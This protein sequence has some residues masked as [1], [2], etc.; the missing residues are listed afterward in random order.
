MNKLELIIYNFVK[1]NPKLKQK[2][3]DL[4][5][6]LLG[7]IPQKSIKSDF[8]FIERKGYFYGFHDKSPFSPNGKNLLAHKIL[9]NYQKLKKESEIEI[10]YFSGENWLNYTPIDITTG[11][12]WQLG[13]MLQWRGKSNEEIVYNIEISGKHKSRIKNIK[14][15]EI[16]KELPWAISHISPDGEYGC[17]Y[18]FHRAEKAMPGY[19]LISENPEINIDEEDF[20]RIFNI[21]TEDVTYEVSIDEIKK[22]NPQSSMENAFHFFHHT[23][24][25]PQSKRVFFLHRWLD[26]NNRRWTRM[27][28]VDVNGENL[29]L[30]PM[31]EMVSHITWASENEIFAYLRYPNDGEGYYLVEDFTGKQ[32]RFFYDK[33]N[34]DGHPTLLKEKNIVITDSYPDR[35]R[36]QYLILMDVK[37]NTRTDLMRTHLPKLFR[38][39]LQVDLHPRFHTSENIVCVD[40]AHTGQHSLITLN[41]T[42]AIT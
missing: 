34:S 35:Y 14:T 5:Q 41:Y 29:Y 20:F 27:F 38:N 11:W 32:K 3:V 26:E 7:V 25:N 17:S 33:L 23:L 18:N 15:K 4:Y 39:Y 1:D 10:G 16:V 6:N 22:I 42:K 31:D 2:I 12:N 40:S 28:S 21:E 13:S 19:G 24:F 30:F 8:P 9:V 37:N 36:N